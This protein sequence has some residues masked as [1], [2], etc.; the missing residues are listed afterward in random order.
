ME[1]LVGGGAAHASSAGSRI[2]GWR[3]TPLAPGG[4]RGWRWKHTSRGWLDW[5]VALSAGGGRGWRWKHARA[6][7]EWIGDFFRRVR[8]LGHGAKIYIHFL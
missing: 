5:G 2:H 6:R 7:V 8:F 4:G 1:E 3:C